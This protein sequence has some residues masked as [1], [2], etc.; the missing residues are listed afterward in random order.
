M[1]LS[2]TDITAALEGTCMPL[3]DLADEWDVPEEALLE[4]IAEAGEVELCTTCGWW[5]ASDE[6]EIIDDEHTCE[7]CR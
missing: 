7:D 3:G 4:A 1:G 6:L 5:C 2:S